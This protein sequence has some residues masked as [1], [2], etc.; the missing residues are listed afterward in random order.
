MRLVPRLLSILILVCTEDIAAGQQ[1]RFELFLQL[2]HTNGITSV[3]LSG[4]GKHAV[5][6]AFDNMAILWRAADG[7]KLQTYRGHTSWI[8]FVAVSGDGKMVV[9]GSNDKSAILWDAASGKK[10]RPF[11]H[12]A[13]G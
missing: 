11:S 5:T 7:K 3:A 13:T 12:T 4:D 1:P 2:G 9:T 6:G 8:T 10:F